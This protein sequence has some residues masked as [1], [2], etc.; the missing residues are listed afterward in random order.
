MPFPPKRFA[1]NCGKF[2]KG[3]V[4]RPE[5]LKDQQREAGSAAGTPFSRA[6][7]GFPGAERIKWTGHLLLRLFLLLDPVL[8]DQAYSVPVPFL[9]SA[10]QPASIVPTAAVAA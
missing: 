6:Q 5:G 2:P 8:R 9:S 4:A 7:T 1:P 10:P 3:A